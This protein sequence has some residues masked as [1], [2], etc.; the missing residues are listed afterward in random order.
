[1]NR[2]TKL[3]DRMIPEEEPEG[4]DV[5]DHMVDID[6]IMTKDDYLALI[7]YRKEKESTELVSHE[8]LKISMEL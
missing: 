8:Y 7:E 4:K 2:H 1:M 3:I 5:K 6:C